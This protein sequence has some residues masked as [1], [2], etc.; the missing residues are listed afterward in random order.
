MNRAALIQ[1][2]RDKKSVL[3]V[4]LDTDLTKIP[5]HLVSEPD[6]AFA[7]NKAIID[8]TKDYTVAYKLNTA[9]YEAQGIKGWES[10]QKTLAYIPKDI[11]T[12]ADAKR[13]D[14][15]NTA[16]Q[17]AKTFFHTYP[18]DSVTVAP[19]MGEDS[20]KPFMQFDG[21][22]AIVLGL[23]SNKGSADFQLQPSG[24][25]LVYEKV[26][27]TVASWGSPDN[28]MF[29]IGAT[30]KEQLQHVRSLLP[31][32]FFLVPGVGAQGGDVATVC[33]NAMNN[34]AGIL[35]N[36]SRGVIYVSNGTDFAEKA[37]EAAADYQ[38]QMAAY[39]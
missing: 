9:F 31:E 21:H 2:I 6:P 18:F 15:G 20:V 1:T 19:Y 5:Q 27:K 25:E 38:Q 7:F 14:I 3:C 37:G 29:V 39:L 36:V 17:Y 22:W 34:D 8:A 16:E 35:I 33:S 26:L 11:F 30:R 32:H 28:T 10:M 24:N 23:T 4:G 13:G 12:I